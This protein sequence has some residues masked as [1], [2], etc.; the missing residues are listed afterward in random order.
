MFRFLCALVLPLVPAVA[1]WAAEPLKPTHADVAYGDDPRQVLDFYQAK[2]EKPT[3]LLFFVHGGGWLGGDKRTFNDMGP[4][5]ARGI[6]VVSVEY[7][8]VSQ[9][10]D[11]GVQPPVQWPL[12]DAAHALQF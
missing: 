1:A 11:A 5:L 3:P 2:S 8:L 10:Q 7:R 9:A 6:S 4:Y 12:H